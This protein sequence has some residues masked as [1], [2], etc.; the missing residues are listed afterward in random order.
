[1]SNL[2]DHCCVINKAVIVME[3]INHGAGDKV[4]NVNKN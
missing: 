1:M 4:A 2:C 3:Q